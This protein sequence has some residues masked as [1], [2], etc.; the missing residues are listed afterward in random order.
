MWVVK[1]IFLSI[2]LTIALNIALV[3]WRNRKR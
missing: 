2:V 3:R 1:S